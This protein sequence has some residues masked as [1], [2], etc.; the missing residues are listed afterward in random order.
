MHLEILL[1]IALSAWG[2]RRVSS[3]GNAAEAQVVAEV[4]CSIKLQN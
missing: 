1:C 4:L 3:N 2:Q